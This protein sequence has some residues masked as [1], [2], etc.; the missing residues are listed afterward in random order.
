M[1]LPYE[2]DGSNQ[3]IATG[4]TKPLTVVPLKDVL[5]AK[6]K[7]SRNKQSVVQKSNSMMEGNCD[8]LAIQN[9]EKLQYKLRNLSKEKLK[10]NIAKAGITKEGLKIKLKKENSYPTEEVSKYN[11]SKNTNTN[12]SIFNV[13]FGN[14]KYPGPSNYCKRKVKENKTKTSNSDN[15]TAQK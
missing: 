11:N 13:T 10:D 3:L 1:K 6:P 4:S 5:R 9:K 7:Y 8:S 14:L 2:A 12:T 15:E